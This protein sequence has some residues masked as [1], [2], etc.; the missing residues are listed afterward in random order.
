MPLPE[1][2]KYDAAA[3]VPVRPA[4]GA[5]TRETAICPACIAIRRK[6]KVVDRHS[7]VW[8]GCLRAP[9]PPPSAE[10]PIPEVA[11]DDQPPEPEEEVQQVNEISMPAVN[12]VSAC[13]AVPLDLPHAC[14]TLSEAATWGSAEPSVATDT[15]APASD[16]ES[17]PSLLHGSDTE[18]FNPFDSDD[19]WPVRAAKSE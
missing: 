14:L 12:P 11:L 16:E 15:E 17:M 1:P 19:E 10:A 13:A 5:A 2:E 8:G 3:L 9:P 6:R 18:E 7:L 4:D